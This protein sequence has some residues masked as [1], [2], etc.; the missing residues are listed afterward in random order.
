MEIVYLGLFQKIADWVFSK[1]LSPVFSFI[2]NLL[3]TVFSFIF[4][5]VLAPVLMPV[6]ETA[7]SFLIDLWKQLVCTQYYLMLTALLKLIEYLETAFDTFIGLKDVS[8][9]TTEGTVTGPLLEV[10]FQQKSVSTLFWSLTL[11]GLAIAL[12]LTIIATARSSFDLDFENKRPVSKVLSAFFK[13]FISLFTIPFF[14]YFILKLSM[15]ILKGVSFAIGN[16]QDFNLSRIIFVIVS[17]NAAKNDAYNLSSA[18]SAINGKLGSS[19]DIVRYPFYTGTK[20]YA[21]MSEVTDVFKLAE[22]DYLIG[23]IISIFVIFTLAI[24]LIIFIQRIFEVLLLY[25]VSPYFVAMM[26][27]DDGEKFSR[28]RELFIGKCFTGFGSVIAMR[29]YL[30]LVPMVMDNSIQFD[31]GSSPEAGYFVKLFFMAGGAWAVYKMGPMV[32]SLLSQQAGQSEM[33][34]GN[35]VGGALF[36]ATA[37]QLIGRG[38]AALMGAA[39]NMGSKKDSGEKKESAAADSQAFRGSKS[40]S[41]SAGGSGAKLLRSK[42][43]PLGLYEKKQRAGGVSEKKLLGGLYSS[44]SSPKGTGSRSVLKGLYSSEKEEG[45]RTRIGVGFGLYS[46]QDDKAAG[47]STRRYLGGLGSTVRDSKGMTVSRSITPLL[48]VGKGSDGKWR[49]TKFSVPGIA[50]IEGGADGG[51]KLTNLH[52]P[53]VVRAQASSGDGKLRVTDVPIIGKHVQR[54]ENGKFVSQSILGGLYQSHVDAEGGKTYSFLGVE[55]YRADW[56]E[57][58]AGSSQ[59]QESKISAG[60]RTE[61][62]KGPVKLDLDLNQPLRGKSDSKGSAGE[63]GGGESKS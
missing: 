52:I 31:L 18:N 28:W 48:S 25:I 1:I 47:T 37:G 9:V 5:N 19:A 55:N 22:F 17:M 56:R 42:R 27:L 15:V 59:P 40:G 60:V 43:L 38:K 32:T 44:S 8:Y 63:K 46:R 39:R 51:R 16:G 45:K 21:K 30:M 20:N 49:V 14:T 50:K 57:K 58:T 24:C 54:D 41:L 3:S 11:G 6:L 34:T 12:V 33:M 36:G 26:P 29:L 62:R 13:T 4:E 10:L 2:S 23:F 61:G 7:I 35:M 53:G